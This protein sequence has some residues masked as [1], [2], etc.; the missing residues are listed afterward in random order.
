MSKVIKSFPSKEKMYLAKS[1][2]MD[3]YISFQVLLRRVHN[4][5]HHRESLRYEER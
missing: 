1:N 2:H 3:I 4:A 5:G